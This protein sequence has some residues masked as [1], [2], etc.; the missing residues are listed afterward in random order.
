VPGCQRARVPGRRVRW[1]GVVVVLASAALAAAQD[2]LPPVLTK[3]VNDV[4]N[5]I[6][7]ASEREIERRILTL[8]TKTGDVV[9]VATVPTFQPYADIREYAVK[10]FENHGKGIG[11]RSKDNGV[12]I[13]VAVEDRKVGIEV[14][15]G[16]EADITDGF[17]G[18]TIREVILPAF[19]QGRYGEGLLAG[20]TRIVNRIAETRG[21]TL[22]DVP[23]TPAATPDDS[24]RE[25]S[26]AG[27]VSGLIFFGL[28]I[29]LILMS[30]RRRRRRWGPWGRG[31]WSGWNSG[32]GPFGGGFGG[33]SGGFGGG[34]GG[35][36]GGGG[37][38]FG[39]FGGG[40]SGGGGASGGW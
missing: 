30:R 29:L 31:P 19:R 5:V 25:R 16:L 18:Q 38:G 11:D 21:V 24:A 20:T 33:S 3:P 15:Y 12:L 10:M 13:V 9:I 1:C 26:P 32:V 22:E 8:Q 17:A 23:R 28:L 4:A 40:R 14:G 35:F 34:F 2:P 39:G 27:N 37:G 36:G 6:D 7:D